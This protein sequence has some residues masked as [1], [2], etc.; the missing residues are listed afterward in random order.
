MGTAAADKSCLARALLH[1]AGAVNM[2]GSIERGSTVS[3]HDPL[4]RRMQHSLTASVMHLHSAGTRVH[5]IDTPAGADFLGHSLPALE[6]VE[7]AAV[8]INAAVGIEPMTLRMRAYAGSRHL[9]RLIVV[10]RIDAT[11]EKLP[12]LLAQIRETFGR[13]CLPLNLPDVGGTRVVDCFYN[14]SGPADFKSALGSVADAHR[15]LVEQVVEV[16]G[17]FVERYL[18]DGDID[19]A[20]LHAPLEHALREGQLI[21]VCFVSARTGAEVA[22]LL[23]IIVR[24]LPNP[25]E[26]NPPDFI[27]GEGAEAQPRHTWPDAA[28][29]VLAHVFKVAFDR[30]VGSLGAMRVHQGTVRA[31]SLVFTGHGHK[32]FK[33]AHLSCCRARNPWRCSR[34]C[35]ATSWPRPR[36]MRSTPTPCCT[37]PRKTNTS[38]CCRWTFRCRCT[39]WPSRPSAMAT[40]SGCGKSSPSWRTKTRA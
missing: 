25:L 12:A 19:A 40:S 21:P 16:D 23:D 2:P 35:R 10:N 5:L 7:T 36:S 9:D 37:T 11:P 4:E 30:Y 6:A 18:A 1:R 8:L 38:I 17:D 3:D 15:A 26:A 27:H 20:E 24:L 39:A 28:L 34:P 32:P 13:E 29:Q 14:R 31:G 33:V 22:E